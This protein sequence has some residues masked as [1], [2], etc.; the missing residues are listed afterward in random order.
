M[1]E[2]N[3]RRFVRK[4]PQH[5]T[6]KSIPARWQTVGFLCLSIAATLVWSTLSGKDLNWDQLN[7]HFYAGYLLTGDRLG[8]DFLAANIQSY[9]NPLVHFP[10][11]WMVSQHWHSLLIAPLFAIVHALNVVLAYFIGRAILGAGADTRIAAML[12]AALAFLSPIFLLEAGTTLADI[13]T[14]VLVLAGVWFALR[15]DE[16]STR[17]VLH[18]AVLAGL[19][20]GSAAGLKL[21][22][23]IFVLPCALILLVV[24]PS[25]RG[26]FRTM[27]SFAVA[28]V[29]GLAITHG[30]WSWRLWEEFRNPFLP[31]FN[32]TFASPDYPAINHHHDRFLPENWM[33]SALLPF[34]MVQLRSWIYVE[35][36][37]PDLRFAALVLCA[38]VAAGVF[39]K[40]RAYGS[41]LA[42][43]HR[44]ATALIAFFCSAYI[45]WSHTSGNGRYGIVLS[46]LC[47][48]LLA[49]LCHTLS[50]RK[51]TALLMLATLIV[52]QSFHLR[53]GDLRW[54][55]GPWTPAWYETSIP[56]QLRTD[57]YLYV[58]V[59]EASNAYI[60]PFLAPGSAYT[61]PIGQIS[62]DL[63]GPGG[64]RLGKLFDTYAGRIRVISQ[65]QSVED[66]DHASLQQWIYRTNTM[67]S[68]LGL[69]IDSDDCLSITTSG[70]GRR[71]GRDFTEKDMSI[72]RLVT[73][74]AIDRPM[75]GSEIAERQRIE[76]IFRR[77]T[78]SCPKLFQPDYV[79]VE[80]VPGGWF[81]NYSDSDKV[82]H[83]EGSRV[84]VT[85]IGAAANLNL[86]SIE[87]WQGP[88]SPRLD[89]ERMPKKLRRAFPVE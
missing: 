40:R 37:A 71:L 66:G 42:G 27:A 55:R 74:R 60:L 11:H 20:L 62:I 69:Q 76:Q 79:V 47:G 88:S 25:T 73:C 84:F 5:L 31:F 86:G 53:Q 72:R 18:G 23:L 21:S 83:L 19:S 16:G 80:K 44:Q 59:G 33:D 54:Q 3:W 45:L 70:S 82:L 43:T 28:W 87:D 30:Y 58:S 57:P 67:V 17:W 12:G 4:T 29:L 52:L 6:I 8:Q 41:M 85:E 75:S 14:S 89:C 22:N 50:R 15:A 56:D 51:S 63:Q 64:K 34:R 7:Y 49:L 32:A 68:R 61:N 2:T 48:P 10:F 81:S 39:V 9:L 35:N 36:V 24:I 46:L 26:R 13:T 77:I 78:A 38:A 1:A 65:A